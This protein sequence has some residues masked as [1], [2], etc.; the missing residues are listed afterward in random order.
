MSTRTSFTLNDGSQIPSIGLGTWQLDGSKG[1]EAITFAL[2]NGYRMLDCAFAYLN[3]E[4]VAAALR[5]AGVDRSEI[6]IVDKLANTWH[7]AAEECLNKTLSNLNVSYLDLWLM[8]WPSPLRH[9]GNHPD[10]PT[11]PD[12]SIDFEPDWDIVKTWKTMIEIQSRRPSE[13]KRIGVANFD[14]E[15]LE[16]IIKATGVIPVVNQVELHPSCN[17]QKLHEY[18]KEKGIQLVA[19]SPLGSIGSPLL[20]DESLKSIAERKD[21]SIAQCL[22]SWG[23]A[24]GWP[25]IPRSSSP[26]RLL[27]NHKLIELT[28]EDLDSITEIGMKNKQRFVVPVHHTF[29]EY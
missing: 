18:C 15:E 9:K 3:Q 6:F 19:Y 4:V 22:L 16:L 25:V 29:A 14:I 7:P 23:V 28:Q 21:A 1:Y 5:Y 12:G 17:L 13:V 20:N 26:E 24:Q 11:R 27:Q 8:H 10:E 2:E